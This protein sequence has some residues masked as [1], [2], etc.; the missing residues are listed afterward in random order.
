MSLAIVKSW[1][2]RTLVATQNL[3]GLYCLQCGAP[4]RSDLARLGRDTEVGAE[5]NIRVVYELGIA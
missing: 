3:S 5:F 1:R 2:V 4:K